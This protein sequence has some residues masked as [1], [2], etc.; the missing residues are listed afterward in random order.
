M[1]DRLKRKQ[2]ALCYSAFVTNGMLALSIGSLL[3]FIRDAFGLDY[4]F[5]GLLVSLHSI[6]NLCSSFFSGALPLLI[7][8]KRSILFFQSFFPVS[9]LLMLLG[10][11]RLILVFAFFATGIARGAASNYCNAK[12]NSIATGM[13]WALNCLHASF[14]VGA[15]VFP[16]ILMFMTRTE[17]SNWVY[18]CVFLSALGLLTCLFY[19]LIPED[20]EPLKKTSEPEASVKQTDDITP[21]ES[22]KQ[23][24]SKNTDR[25]A[26]S[27]DFFREPLFYICIAT[28]FFYLC[29]EQGVI[30]WMITYFK[31][32]GLLQPNLAQ[33]TASILWIMILL[34]RLTTAFLST[35][36]KKED[37]LPAMG[38]GI[39]LFFIVLILSKTTL[40]IIIGIM[41]FGF[42]MAGI[43]ATTVS[44][45]GEL[46]KKYSLAWSFILTT[47]S[48]GS[49]IMPTIVGLIAE[50]FGIA[51]GIGSIAIALFIDMICIMILVH[52]VRRKPCVIQTSM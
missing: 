12:I 50:N 19:Y 16:L 4:A 40:P 48:L 24:G 27:F 13:A 14:A 29:A 35:K 41:G 44:F 43:Y 49:I 2:F 5:C 3:P 30:G 36:V 21:S 42:S 8:K 17:S 1:T 25:S 33:V 39:V 6:G 28:L 15:F 34:G 11:Y 20:P 31:D 9:F 26:A 52:F 10:N 23:P 47:A 45:A 46:I 18:A 7:G 32:T 51:T 38:V 37:L 22:V